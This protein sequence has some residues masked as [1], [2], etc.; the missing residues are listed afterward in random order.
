MPKSFML[1]FYHTESI[2]GASRH[3]VIISSR[4]VYLTAE[5]LPYQSGDQHGATHCIPVAWLYVSSAKRVSL[6]WAKIHAQ[7]EAGFKRA[8]RFCAE[9]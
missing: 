6:A 8:A 2:F 4:K 1:R 7:Y 9:L 5:A 3:L